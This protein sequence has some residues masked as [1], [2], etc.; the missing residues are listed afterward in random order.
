MYFWR[1]TSAIQIGIDQDSKTLNEGFG[2]GPHRVEL[3]FRWIDRSPRQR[4]DMRWEGIRMVVSHI[5]PLCG[6]W[7]TVVSQLLDRPEQCREAGHAS[8]DGHRNEV[9]QHIDRHHECR[10]DRRSRTSS[11]ADV[12]PG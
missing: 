2:Q 9:E 5:A 3:I 11:K 1:Q 4:G 6:A 10:R 8:R 7:E 12:G